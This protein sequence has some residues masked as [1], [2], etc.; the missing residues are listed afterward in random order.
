MIRRS[1]A[2]IATL[3]ALAMLLGA[4]GD[5]DEDLDPTEA[6]R[7]TATPEPTATVTRDASSAGAQDAPPTK[8]F[9][10]LQQWDAPPAMML[11]D[12]VDYRARIITNFGD[13][14]VDLF[15]GEAPNTVNNFVFLANQGF[16]ENVPIH[17]VLAGFVIQSGDPTGTGTGGPGYRFADE[18][19]VRDYTRGTLAMANAGPNTNGSQF[20]ITL[21]DLSGQLPKNYTIF[22]EVVEGL[23]VVDQIAQVPV[24]RGPSGEASSPTEPVFIENIEIITN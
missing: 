22:G 24:Q 15:E 6:P 14:T 3:A 20:F 2:L 1:L 23:D 4:C 13:V 16:Y 8:G 17:R 19:V 7:N 10:E 5:A 11:E 9:D 21:A 12:G 18:P